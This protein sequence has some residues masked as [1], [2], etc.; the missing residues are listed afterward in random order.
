MQQVGDNAFLGSGT[1]VNWLVVREG[2]D[3]TVVDA[4]YPGDLG[5]LEADLASLGHHPRD[6]RAVLVTHNHVDHVGTLNH[7]HATYGTPALVHPD[8]IPMLRGERKEEA[9]PVDVALRSWR[10]SVLAWSIRIMR[11]GALR[12]PHV[13]HAEAWPGTHG[14]DLPGR[15]VPVPCTGHTS[16]HTAYHFAGAGVVA[17][18]DALVT[19]HAIM[20]AQGPQRVPDFFSHAPEEARASLAVLADLD[21]DTIAPGHGSVWRGDLHE[22]VEQAC[23]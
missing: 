23:A 13:M 11:A 2:R 18:G 4:G 5:R 1:D 10:P 17:S 9:S 22:A 14:L 19:G 12:H 15:P 20:P 16:G 6:I 8:E 7:L 21:A 3:L